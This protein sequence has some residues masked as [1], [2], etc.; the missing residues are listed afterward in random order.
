VRA[1]ATAS[2]LLAAS[3]AHASPTPMITPPVGWTVDAEQAAQLAAKVNAQQHLGGA[4]VV[5]ATE[6]YLPPTPGVALF[7]TRITADTLVGTRAQAARAAIEDL[8]ASAA[9]AYDWRVLP[10]GVDKVVIA[11]GEW[12]DMTLHTQTLGT[13]V[14]AAN[15]A[16]FVTVRGECLSSD[17]G[18]ADEIHACGNAL[19]TLDPGIP[20]E[21]RIAFEPAAESALPL[22]TAS[23]DEPS[24]ITDG[25]NVHLSP[26]TIGATRPEAD[27]RPVYLGAGIVVMAA[28]FWWNRRRRERFE[29]EDEVG[30]AGAR[31]ARERTTQDDDADDLAAAARGDAPK[32]ET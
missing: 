22:S 13:V 26:M 20:V 8:H 32:D 19:R 14:I 7:V 1:I 28:V 18:S 17:A 25:Q 12:A 10:C 5:A 2:V 31:R 16:R 4:T 6:V 30:T 23:R 29:R 27:R 3:I 11:H 15:T 24:R 9:Q 21:E